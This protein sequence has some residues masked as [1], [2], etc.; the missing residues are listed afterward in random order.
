MSNSMAS[1]QYYLSGGKNQQASKRPSQFVQPSK[2]SSASVDKE[3]GAN[4]RARMQQN[5]AVQPFKSWE[6][7]QFQSS[8]ITKPSDGKHAYS[9]ANASKDKHD[10]AKEQFKSLAGVARQGVRVSVVRQSLG[11]SEPNKQVSKSNL[12]I[13]TDESDARINSDGRLIPFPF[14]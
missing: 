2:A 9:R 8:S 11:K 5:Y 1:D 6:R 10:M 4:A 14:L 13:E 12:P 3:N 7:H